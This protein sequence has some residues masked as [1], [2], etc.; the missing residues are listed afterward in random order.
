MSDLILPVDQDQSPFD[1]IRR[2]D[3]NGKEYW[4]ARE[5]MV[6]VAYPRWAD[7]KDVIARAEFACRNT[8]NQVIEH[9]SGTI[10]KNPNSKTGRN[11]S[12]VFLSRYGAYLVAMNGDP[13]KPEVAA[14]QSYFAIKTFEAEV[15]I[16]KQNDELEVLRLRV[17]LA[18]AERDAAIA[19][20]NLLDTRKAVTEMG[21]QTVSALILGA[22]VITD[23]TPVERTIMPDGRV[24][25]G[26]GIQAIA[27]KLG[28]GKNTQAC[29]QWL[30]S[31]GY[32]KNTDHWEKQLTAVEHH[33][34]NPDA[35]DNILTKWNN[36]IRQRFVG[37]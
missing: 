33:K 12:D 23:K 13:R 22:T 28:F 17:Q 30:E 7:F 20:K 29:W 2:L 11:Q 34:L 37:E 1:S 8:G 18:E 15:I 4:S 31:I 25:E 24:F 5:L 32:G 19:Q 9:F 27:K 35:Y 16:P 14:A 6:L 36:G 26:V 21:N 10:L 3:E